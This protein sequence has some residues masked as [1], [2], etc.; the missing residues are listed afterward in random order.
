MNQTTASICE[1]LIRVTGEALDWNDK[2]SS[3]SHRVH[4]DHSDNTHSFL[5]SRLAARKLKGSSV[6][7]PCV[8]VFGP[9]QAGK[10]YLVS[11]LSK[12]SQSSLKV[13]L[14]SEYVDFLQKINPGGGR[15]ST[16]VVTR[17]LSPN[18][19]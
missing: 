2:A 3:A 1:A 9:S 6:R 5:R 13:K 10:S 7:A 15:E 16:G 18:P 4:L 14:G 12:G 19:K 17:F 8:G 11:A